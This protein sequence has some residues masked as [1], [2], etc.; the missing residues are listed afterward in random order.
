MC[1]DLPVKMDVLVPRAYVKLILIFMVHKNDPNPIKISLTT[2]TLNIALSWVVAQKHLL[3]LNNCIM[4]SLSRRIEGIHLSK[5][6]YLF[7]WV[8]LTNYCYTFIVDMNLKSNNVTEPTGNYMGDKGLQLQPHNNTPYCHF[9]SKK[10]W[11]HFHRR[12]YCFGRLLKV[13]EIWTRVAWRYGIQDLHTRLVP[14]WTPRRKRTLRRGWWKWCMV[15]A[16]GC[17]GNG[18]ANDK[19]WA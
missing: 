12:Q 18:A 13:W 1:I 15:D 6:Y 16:C 3:T 10:P 19:H 7:G 8:K 11:S 9:Y 14:R 17:R 2:C 5:Y 4:R